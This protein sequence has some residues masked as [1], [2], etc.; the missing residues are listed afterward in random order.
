MFVGKE[1]GFT[2]LV[3][4]EGPELFPTTAGY[5]IFICTSFLYEEKSV[6]PLI[7]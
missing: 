7:L 1:V 2:G 3:Y 6:S 4:P 5:V